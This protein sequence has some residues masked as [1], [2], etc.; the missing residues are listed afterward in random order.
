MKKITPVFIFSL[1]RSGSTLLQRCI[2]LDERFS[3]T[4]ETWLLLPILGIL[5]KYLHYSQYSSRHSVNAINDLIGNSIS[6]ERF[7]EIQKKYIMDLFTSLSQG[8]PFFIE[9][10]PRN[11]WVCEEIIN[12]FN[13]EARY[14]FLWRNPVDIASSIIDTWGGGAWN[15]YSYE[16]DFREGFMRLV[17][18]YKSNQS[19]SVQI[20]Y[21]DLINDPVKISNRLSEYLGV[22]ELTFDLGKLSSNVIRGK[23]GDPTGQ[24][25]KKGLEATTHS[26]LDSWLRQKMFFRLIRPVIS[27]IE[28]CGYNIANMESSLAQNT[29]FNPVVIV[30]DLLSSVYGFVYKR[31]Q[32]FILRDTKKGRL[33]GAIR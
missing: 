12:L 14:I 29:T 9:K 2:T 26:S 15:L 23:M 4:P 28:F 8:K 21:E 13:N 17:H 32:P 7:S 1:P 6:A 20:T 30:N 25:Q 3:T 31:F 27:E 22:K 11:Y 24:Y 10:T 19:L 5:K 33:K 18:C 16:S